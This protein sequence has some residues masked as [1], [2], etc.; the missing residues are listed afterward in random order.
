MT[1]IYSYTKVSTPYTTI[2]MAL[3][4]NQ[5]LDDALRCTE[6]CTLDGVTYVAVPDEVVLPDQPAEIS[7]SV[8]TLTDALRDQIKAA[9][10]HVALIA[11]RMVDKIRAKYTPED[12]M[13]FARI[14]IG[15][16]T[17]QYTFETGE[18][19]AVTAYGAHVEGVRQ[20]GRTE[21]AKLGL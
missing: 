7:A 13:Y 2:Q 21:K 5:G 10:V 9:S 18:Q 17:G 4:D 14:S 1:S 12:E 3:P 15:A 11:E 16:L 20:W 8:V 6:L 19:A